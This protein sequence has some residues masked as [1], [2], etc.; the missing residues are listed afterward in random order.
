M[1]RHNIYLMSR[2]YLIC[3]HEEHEE[4][5]GKRQGDLSNKH[6]ARMKRSGI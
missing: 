1:K 5:E 6:A 3:Y 4:N 2:L